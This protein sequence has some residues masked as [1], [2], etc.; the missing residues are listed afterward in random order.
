MRDAGKLWRVPQGYDAEIGDE[1]EQQ[2]FS[3]GFNSQPD[4]D[5]L[6][7]LAQLAARATAKA[8][9]ASSSIATASIQD[10][11]AQATAAEE[12]LQIDEQLAL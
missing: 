12:Y 6:V 11:A 9:G 7:P 5:D 3:K 4:K 2:L 10:V 8:A 1:D